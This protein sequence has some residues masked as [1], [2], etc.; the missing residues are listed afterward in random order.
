M[1]LAGFMPDLKPGYN[2]IR[3]PEEGSHSGARVS[4][5]PESPAANQINKPGIPD[6]VLRTG[7]E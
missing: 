2:P 7:P 5:N 4:A 1:T 6:P 3:V